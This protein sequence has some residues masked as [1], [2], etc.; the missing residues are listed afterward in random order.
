MVLTLLLLIYLTVFS[1]WK[2]YNL[3]KNKTFYYSR[4][5][6]GRYGVRANAYW[7]R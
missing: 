4:G 6:S 1:F 7:L 5:R 2:H 3:M